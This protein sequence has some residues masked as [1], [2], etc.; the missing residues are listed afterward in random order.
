MLFKFNFLHLRMEKKQCGVLPY[1]LLHRPSC[2][3]KTL[4][5][6]FKLFLLNLDTG[7]LGR[8]S[9]HLLLFQFYLEYSPHS[10]QSFYLHFSPILTSKK[11]ITLSRTTLCNLCVYLPFPV[12]WVTWDQGLALY[13]SQ[14]FPQYPETMYNMLLM[15]QYL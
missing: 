14:L 5:F 12:T 8:F 9:P 2:T 1:A 4:S 10:G 13:Y 15:H 11:H 6:N 3:S 7:C